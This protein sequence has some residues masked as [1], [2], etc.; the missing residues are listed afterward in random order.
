MMVVVVVQLLFLLLLMA[1]TPVVAA[2]CTT[3]GGRCWSVMLQVVP[4]AVAPGPGP[5]L[6]SCPVLSCRPVR[7]GC[8]A[9]PFQI[10]MQNALCTDGAAIEHAERWMQQL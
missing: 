2:S 6:H 7:Q 4:P 9:T 10:T 8:T 5:V 1:V 3:G